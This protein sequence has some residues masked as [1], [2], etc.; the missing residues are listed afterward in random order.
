MLRGLSEPN[1]DIDTQPFWQGCRDDRFLIPTCQECETPRW[2]PG[3]ACP[4][5]QSQKVVWIA[6]LGKGRIYSWAIVTH[7]IA[8]ATTDE[9]PY[10][11]ALIDLG[12]G[13]RVVGN[14][15]DVTPAEMKPG[16]P[17]ELF[18]E[19]AGN[20]FRLPNFRHQH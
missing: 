13:V 12:E 4:K 9:V 15:V 5:C 20:G 11:I 8:P 14:V 16:M 1:A 17:V 10:V 7:A 18:F 3:P 2:P 19:D 6:S